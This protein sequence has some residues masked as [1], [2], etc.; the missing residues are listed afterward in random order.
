MS[1]RGTALEF[2]TTEQ[3]A[4]RWQVNPATVLGMAKAGRIP[5]VKIGRA[6]R[7]P[8]EGLRRWETAHLLR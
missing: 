7:Y 3:V 2:L 6:Y 8:F 5:C 1:T 4:G